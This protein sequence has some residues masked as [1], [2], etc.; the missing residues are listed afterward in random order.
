MLLSIV[1]WFTIL[2]SYSRIC[3]VTP[4]S[5]LSIRVS[6]I[7]TMSIFKSF[8]WVFWRSNWMWIW[9]L[10]NPILTVSTRDCFDLKSSISIT[11][12]TRAYFNIG[13]R[14]SSSRINVVGRKSIICVCIC[15]CIVSICATLAPIISSTPLEIL[16]AS[17]LCLGPSWAFS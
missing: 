4:N 14:L 9:R 8:I 11:L 12:F 7:V 15:Q 2:P 17:L 3:S 1:Q 16:T 10:G 5:I 13:L 6:T